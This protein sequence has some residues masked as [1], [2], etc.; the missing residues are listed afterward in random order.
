MKLRRQQAERVFQEAKISFDAIE[1]R[2]ADL[3][4]SI[5]KLQ[6]A[7]SGFAAEDLEH[8]SAHMDWLLKQ[9]QKAHA[10]RFVLKQDY[11]VARTALAKAMLALDQLASAS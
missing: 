6:S 7:D 3:H 1:Q 9:A 5:G 4:D 11:D 2:I 10:E 8:Q